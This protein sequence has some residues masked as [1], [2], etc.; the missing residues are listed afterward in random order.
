VLDLVRESS[1]WAGQRGHALVAADD[2]D[3]S[4][5]QKTYRANLLEER[6]RRII[7]E[8]TQLIDT[9]GRAVGQVNGISVLALG[10]HVFGRPR[11]SPRAPTRASRGWWTTRGRPS[12]AGRSTPRG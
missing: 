6:T 7:T 1:F 12:W 3:H 9:E 10:D 5:A 11:G 8:G 4:I 2:V